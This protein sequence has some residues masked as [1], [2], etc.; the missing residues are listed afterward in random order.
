MRRSVMI[1]A[2]GL[3]TAAAANEVPEEEHSNSVA[4][5]LMEALERAAHG[6]GE[7]ANRPER[8]NVP[9]HKCNGRVC[10]L[11]NKERPY[12]RSQHQ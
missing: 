1:L 5:A 7:A 3:G 6:A 4:E 10:I 2:L 11:L 12:K 8:G 9:R